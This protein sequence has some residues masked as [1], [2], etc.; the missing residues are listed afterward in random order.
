MS[1]GE[2]C[3]CNLPDGDYPL[4]LVDWTDS[5]EN[6]ENSDQALCDLPEPARIFQVGF[7]VVSNESFITVAG[8]AKLESGTVDYAITIP[9]CAIS[10]IR[11]L[12]VCDGPAEGA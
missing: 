4:V 10:S 7:M 11:Y 2:N 3:R 6:I 5:C 1:C 8:G 12:A 9:R